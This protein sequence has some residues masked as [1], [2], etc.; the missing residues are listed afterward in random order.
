LTV[1]RRGNGEGAV[2]KSPDG[3]W[4]GAVDLGWQD[5]KRVR[6]YV[7]GPTRTETVRQLRALQR[8]IDSGVIPDGT[9]TVETWLREWLAGLSG[10][11]IDAT[12]AQYT[13]TVDKHLIPALGRIR[14]DRLTPEHVDKFLLAKA[15]SGLSKSYVSRMRTVLGAALR[16]AEKRGY[17]NRNVALL[18]TMPRAKEPAP[19]RSLT[20]EEARQLM[21][22]A[23]GNR[24]E[25]LVI[26]GLAIGL[27]PGELAGLRWSDVV[28]DG[29]APTLTVS[30]SMKRLV[31]TGRKGYRL[32]RGA[33]KKS[34]NGVRTVALPP[35]AVEALKAHWD[36]QESERLAAGRLW[37]D[38]GLVFATE[39]GTP[40]DPSN[41]RRRFAEL[42]K[43]AGLPADVSFVYVMRHSLV[44]LLLDAGASI[45]EVADVVGDDPRTLYKHYRHQVRPV[46]RATTRMEAVLGRTEVAEGDDE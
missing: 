41:L 4:R 25:G 6:R 15:K 11:I 7:S 29:D 30:G 39:I 5:G 43:R 22:A 2:Y 9:L 37:Q 3:R 18:A 45:E 28:L 12:L 27:R 44:S 33:V 23:V 17:I 16:H 31:K 1:A 19:R 46:A 20:P 34:S 42:V 38:H 35:L 36:R 14:L 40:L 24:L 32:E 26:L 13:A 21:D 10:G 8:K